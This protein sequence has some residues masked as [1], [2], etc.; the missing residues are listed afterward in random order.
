MV[1]DSLPLLVR[2]PGQAV[3]VH[4]GRVV[5]AAEYAADVDALR[6]RLPE[7]ACVIN[8]CE[9]RYRFMVGFGAALTR[10][11]STLL[12]PNPLPETL[13]AI[14]AAWPL[15]VV[16]ADKPAFTID[17]MLVSPGPPS[18]SP[19]RLPEISRDVLA[20][21]LFTSGS[22]GPSMPH[23]K[24]WGALVEG[25]RL[26]LQHYLG[27]G[28][29]RGTVVAT[30][31][32]QHMYGLETTVM[33]ALCGRAAAH[34]A[35]PFFPA[36]VLATLREAPSPRILVSTPVHLHALVSSGLTFPDVARILSATAPIDATLA[37]EV[38]RL[39]RGELIEIYG[40]TEVGSMASRR[41]AVGERWRFFDGFD[42]S[43]RDGTT[44]VGAPH[45]AAAF[46]LP[47]HLEFATDGSFALAGRD[48]DLLKVGGKRG[49]L[50]DV[51]RA[52][53][54]V[55]GVE[56]AVAFRVDEDAGDARLAALFV[57]AKIDAVALRASLSQSLDPAFIP[58]PMLRVAELP[59]SPTGKLSRA[60]VLE[61]L[62]ETLASVRGE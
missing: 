50:A 41:A 39:F 53:T 23:R 27:A 26:N 44:W 45:L 54:A 19:A 37:T 40:C 6:R 48:S 47:D 42:I 49:S 46:R 51:N 24:T 38:E 62:R 22:T 11:L 17:S 55:R 1:P 52:L 20:A 13:N 32:A 25:T 4:D 8:L 10:G 18:A 15:N 35:R 30:V 7:A 5:T 3:A 9:D 34:A 33:A 56:D 43:R 28:D 60:A 21:V 31:P 36:D 59:R 2:R 61:L 12:P 14:R 58:R 57:S 16:L 29:A